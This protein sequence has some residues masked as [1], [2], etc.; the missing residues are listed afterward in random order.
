MAIF[1]DGS[2]SFNSVSVGCASVSLNPRNVTSKSIKKIASIFSAECIAII[3]ALDIALNY[4]EQNIMILSDSLSVLSCLKNNRNNTKTNPYIYILKQKIQKFAIKS[5][6]NSQIKFY[7]IP[8]HDGIQGNELA[9]QL[10]KQASNDPP[11]DLVKIPYTDLRAKAKENAIAN[12][13]KTLKE[14]GTYKG[15][16]YFQHFYNEKTNPWF[17]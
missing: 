16:Y 3:D 11:S 6:N 14:E 5:T 17:H 8:A 12:T 4:T 1:T 9:D 15:A 7:W 13:V 10:A 2:K